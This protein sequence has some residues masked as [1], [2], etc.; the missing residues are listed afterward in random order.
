M[1]I[2]YL[3]ESY[4]AIGFAYLWLSIFNGVGMGAKAASDKN[5]NP[6][7][8]LMFKQKVNNWRFKRVH[9]LA[10]LVSVAVVF[11]VVGWKLTHSQCIKDQCEIVG[12]PV[13]EHEYTVIRHADVNGEDLMHVQAR[14][15][16]T[17]RKVCDLF[18]DCGGFNSNGW[19]KTKVLV[20]VSGPA[21]LYV[22]GD[23]KSESHVVNTAL[24]TQCP[25]DLQ[26]GYQE[27][28]KRMK[29]YVYDLM[30]TVKYR[31]LRND[32]YGIERIF[33]E[34]LMQSPLR[35]RKPEEATFFFIPIRCSTYILQSSL[36]YQGIIEAKLYV[37]EM[38]ANI[39]STFPYWKRTNGADH[40][41]ICSHD[42]GA[43]VGTNLLKNVIA[44]VNTADYE[45]PYFVPHKDISLPPKPTHGYNSLASHGKGGY[46]IDPKYRTILAFFAGDVTSGRVRPAMWRHFANDP[47]FTMIDREV[48]HK[49]YIKYLQ[50]SKFCLVPRG[51]EVWSPRLMDAV[52]YGCIP[53]I[54]SDHYHLPLQGIVDWNTFSVIVPEFQ[55]LELKRILLEVSVA[56]VERMQEKLAVVYKKFVWNSPAQ[57]Q[58]AFHSAM[59]LLWQRRHYIRY[60]V[61]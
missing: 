8:P 28:M 56:E 26:D 49:V 6:T 52:F 27:M 39:Q 32:G 1:D 22:K 25:S 11:G 35:T 45:D 48:A 58:D 23:Q 46:G 3:K 15:L 14:D 36:E 55:I 50:Q 54:I 24:S 38:I 60:H 43:G 18:D 57:P 47:D 4:E 37:S 12:T 53:V 34:Q 42:I 29:I 10:V 51:R 44:L 40:F 17:V 31:T 30:S 9:Y 5:Q 20:H 41:Y 16:T 2:F 21:D 19:L 59:L 13:V 7:G 61:R 33:S